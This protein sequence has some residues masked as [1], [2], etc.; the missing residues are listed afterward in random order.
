MSRPW[1]RRAALAGL[2]GLG[3]GALAWRRR[4]L[5][6]VEAARALPGADPSIVQGMTISCPTWG[7]EWGTDAMV[8][9]LA[10]LKTLGV[11]WVAIH[12]YASIADDG[13]VT[14]R[15]LEGDVP[16]T[17]LERPIREAHGLGMKIMIKPHLAYWGSR[18]SWRGAI[19][20]ADP[21]DRDRFWASY[22][23]WIER[24]AG[25]TADADAFVVGTELDRLVA[26]DAPWRQLIGAVRQR[27]AA[28]LTFASNWDAYAALPFWDALDAVGVQAYFPVAPA[29][30]R[31][32]DVDALVAGWTGA[33]E[34]LR[35]IHLSTGK[36]VVFTE[37]GYNDSSEA[38]AQPWATHQG[39]P[40]A[41][42]VQARCLEA[43]LN[44]VGREPWIRGAFLWK[45]FPGD[46][47]TGDF[48][49]SAPHTRDVIAAAWGR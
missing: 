7:W 5:A 36:P 9:T 32:A 28:H 35:A 46:L 10:E 17:W 12:P 43:A 19:E 44:T 40:D 30:A 49:M 21:A 26:D 23:R 38:A 18:F 39:G 4:A 25:M 24:M 6:A 48:R 8:S 37:L 42:T 20:F 13:T 15:A 22:P 3:L 11:N 29:G 41:A 14:T 31:V 1:T 2:G 45:W 33:L 27:T 47:Q 34:G 16:P